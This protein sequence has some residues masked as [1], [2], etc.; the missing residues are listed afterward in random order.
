MITVDGSTVSKEQRTAQC[1]YNLLLCTNVL[2]DH[3]PLS[4]LG[5]FP[6]PWF[7]PVPSAAW[8]TAE[9]PCRLLR[10]LGPSLPFPL[11]GETLHK[12]RF[13]LVSM[14][15]PYK[16]TMHALSLELLLCLLFLKLFSPK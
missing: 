11:R 10:I 8:R 5:A 3:H 2:G 1:H 14:K 4:P 7:P 13:F 16:R 15:F 6:R 9:L 12:G